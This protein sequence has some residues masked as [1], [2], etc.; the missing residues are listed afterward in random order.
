MRRHR[1]HLVGVRAERAHELA[2]RPPRRRRAFVGA[3]DPHDVATVGGGQARDLLGQPGLADAGR[4]RQ[5][6]PSGGACPYAAREP[7]RPWPIHG[8]AP[9]E[10]R[11]SRRRRHGSRPQRAPPVRESPR[12]HRSTPASAAT[13]PARAPD[14]A[15]PSGGHAVRVPARCRVRRPAAARAAC[16]SPAPRRHV[17]PDTAPASAAGTRGRR[18]G[19]R[20]AAGRPPSQRRRH[21]P[22]REQ[23][24]RPCWQHIPRASPRCGQR[25][26]APIP[27]PPGPPVER[28]ATR[29][30]AASA[31]ASASSQRSASTAAPARPHP[32]ANTVRSTASGSTSM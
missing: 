19:R 23:R 17:R 5:H 30:S 11:G 21:P 8:P 12:R 26:H 22:Q 20:R 13:P 29:A 4:T 14:A 31:S 1:E 6:Q 3:A 7:Q 16:K 2:H 32:A 9:P 25:P 10:A 15:S 18:T 24:N 28:P 27:D